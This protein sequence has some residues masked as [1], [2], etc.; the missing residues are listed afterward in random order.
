[1]GEHFEKDGKRRYINI[2][3]RDRE[4]IRIEFVCQM[5][6]INAIKKY[7]SDTRAARFCAINDQVATIRLLG[8]FEED[9]T[10]YFEGTQCGGVVDRVMAMDT[11]L[12][13]LR[14]SR[15]QEEEALKRIRCRANVGEGQVLAREVG[16]PM[17][18]MRHRMDH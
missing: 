12:G 4:R 15:N 14:P 6:W 10:E 16:R 9:V 1:M 7:F 13:N 5:A 8:A 3:N 2:V 11:P 17:G 18:Q